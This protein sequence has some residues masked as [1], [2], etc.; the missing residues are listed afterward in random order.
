[1]NKRSFSQRFA[2]IAF[3]L[4]TIELAH[5]ATQIRRARCTLRGIGPLDGKITGVITIQ[6]DGDSMGSIIHVEASGLYPNATHGFHFHQYGDVSDQAKGLNNGAHFAVGEQSDGARHGSP[7]DL[8]P[9]PHNGDLGNVVA[10]AD[11][12]VSVTLQPSPNPWVRLDGSGYSVIGRAAVIHEKK[13]DATRTSPTGNAG[14]RYAQ[15]VIGLEDTSLLESSRT[16][17]DN[18]ASATPV[19][20]GS[21][22]SCTLAPLKDSVSASKGAEP[23][24]NGE[25]RPVG[26]IRFETNALGY[27]DVSGT[28]Y[29]MP[30]SQSLGVYVHQYGSLESSK[31]IG[32]LW[33]QVLHD[34]QEYAH[35]KDMVTNCRGVSE[36]KDN[37]DGLA[38]PIT[39]LVGRTLA[40]HQDAN[41]PQSPVLAGC[42]LGLASFTKLNPIFRRTV[43]PKAECVFE[44]TV[45]ATNVKG[46][47]TINSTDEY[48]C[49]VHITAHQISGIPVAN[50]ISS[51][52]AQSSTKPILR[53]HENGDLLDASAKRLGNIVMD[54]LSTPV[55]NGTIDG[56][57]TPSNSPITTVKLTGADSIIGRGLSLR[58]VGEDAA[59]TRKNS[60][61]TQESENQHVFAQCVVGMSDIITPEEKTLNLPNTRISQKNA[62]LQIGVAKMSP[63]YFYPPA[64]GQIWFRPLS[65]QTK[66]L[67]VELALM[68]KPSTNY[69]IRIYNHG[70]IRSKIADN[71]PS[72]SL[73][74]ILYPRSTQISD[75]RFIS[76]ADG[77]IRLKTPLIQ[78]P[79]ATN[80][81][82]TLS[83]LLG[84]AILVQ[85]VYDEVVLPAVGFGVIGVADPEYVEPPSL[86]KTPNVE[87]EA[88]EKDNTTLIAASV[89]GAIG[90]CLLLGTLMLIKYRKGMKHI[91]D[92]AKKLVK[93][94][95][96]S[97]LSFGKQLGSGSFGEVYVGSWRGTEVAIKKLNF[98]K[99]TKEALKKFD[100][101]VSVMI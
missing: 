77:Y 43:I 3:A 86:I 60:E 28:V 97:D 67:E 51:S 37:V 62:T 15:C 4:C 22:V 9:R 20:S 8:D 63:T 71:F 16:G 35:L 91:D 85:P 32:P 57:L 45:D 87:Q 59:K 90:A 50:S 70:S 48:D 96:Y 13:D 92:K 100:H 17:I 101:E 18:V 30:P 40:I 58:L 68:A 34:K 14:G 24:P 56:R 76:D 79:S 26:E 78:Q 73:F 27:V 36:Y 93:N 38:F 46:R 6:Q 52:N 33:S 39:R 80:P 61:T 25:I 19:P 41:D 83:Q 69:T 49:A 7:F 65:N 2:L 31:S 1:M 99:I 53:V 12:K 81:Q 64:E 55:I 23:G 89:G 11:G 21:F 75:F 10:D 42:V 94:V 72:E 88:Q 5:G 29:M 95:E 54:L 44:A 82:R 98:G 84:K 74:L 47:L 66:D